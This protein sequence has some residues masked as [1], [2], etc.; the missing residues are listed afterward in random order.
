M[1]FLNMFISVK[2]K[3]VEKYPKISPTKKSTKYWI[4]QF[5][6]FTKN[7]LFNLSISVRVYQ[8]I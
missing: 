2:E 3:N 7:N 1:D 5:T 8:G 4:S 6:T